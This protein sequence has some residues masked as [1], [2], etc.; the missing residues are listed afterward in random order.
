MMNGSLVKKN[1]L[2]LANQ[3]ILYR[4]LIRSEG[5]LNARPKLEFEPIELF[6]CVVRE[7]KTEYSENSTGSSEERVLEVTRVKDSF[8]YKIGDRFIYQSNEYEILSPPRPFYQFKDFQTIQ[9]V[10]R[11]I[12]SWPVESN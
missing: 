10:G 5:V 9:F 12:S 4:K 6:N 3:K 11:Y 8:E 7:T 2:K 1:F